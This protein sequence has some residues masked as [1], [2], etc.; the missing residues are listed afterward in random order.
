MPAW[1]KNNSHALFLQEVV[2]AHDVIDVFHLT[3]DM[4]HASEGGW[5]EF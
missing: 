3:A 1:A 4:L 5:K 2:R